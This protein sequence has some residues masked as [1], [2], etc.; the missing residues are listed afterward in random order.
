MPTGTLAVDAAT[1]QVARRRAEQS[2]DAAW[3]RD[4]T[5]VPTLREGRDTRYLRDMDHTR[6]P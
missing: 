6:I 2:L 4:P 5:A 1:P 3:H